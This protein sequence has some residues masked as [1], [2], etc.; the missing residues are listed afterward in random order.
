[1]SNKLVK[2]NVNSEYTKLKI[3]GFGGHE[4]QRSARKK[5]DYRHLC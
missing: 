3:R 2:K 5:R 1:M 4:K